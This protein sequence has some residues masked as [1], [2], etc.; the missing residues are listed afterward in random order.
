MQ[1]KQTFTDDY[2]VIGSM[3]SALVALVAALLQIPF[4]Y[5]A[6][7]SGKVHA[8]ARG[9]LHAFNHDV[10]MLAHACEHFHALDHNDMALFQAC[11][12][13]ARMCTCI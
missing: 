4:K 5:V 13:C 9:R 1:V 12:H 7:R 8:Y 11:G 2:V 6:R 3:M 10:K